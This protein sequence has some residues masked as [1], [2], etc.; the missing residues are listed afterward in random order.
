MRVVAR[1]AGVG[2]PALRTSMTRGPA[3]TARVPV[4]LGTAMATL[5][6]PMVWTGTALTTA[7]VFRKRARLATTTAL[8]LARAF[9]GGVLGSAAA[10]R[11]R[12][13]DGA[14]SSVGD[15]GAGN[16]ARRLKVRMNK[17]E[18][19]K[20]KTDFVYIHGKYCAA[21]TAQDTLLCYSRNTK[22]KKGSGTASVGGKPL[23]F[24]IP[25]GK[26]S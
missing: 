13:G 22:S 10:G 6:I 24:G 17:F 9:R 1:R 25:T 23:T 12:A 15:A 18:K 20:P 8:A 26:E 16:G 2:T 5:L 11:N 21:G 4:G 19:G 14:V 7:R 3:L